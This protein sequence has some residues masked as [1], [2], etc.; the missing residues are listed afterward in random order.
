MEMEVLGRHQLSF[1]VFN[2]Y[3]WGNKILNFTSRCLLHQD[4]SVL[5]LLII[6][7]HF[8]SIHNLVNLSPLPGKLLLS[9]T[10]SCTHHFRHH[11]LGKTFLI[12]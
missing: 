12:V 7:A 8:V 10:K 1:F 9:L 5:L 2:E 6:W 3:V 11:L 4:P